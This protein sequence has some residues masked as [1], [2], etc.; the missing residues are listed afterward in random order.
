MAQTFFGSL[1]KQRIVDTINARA[2]SLAL[3]A[4][5][6]YESYRQNVGFIEGLKEVLNIC[7]ELEKDH[8]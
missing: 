6:N 8:S 7:E 1:L 3:G 4:A 2:E 5:Q